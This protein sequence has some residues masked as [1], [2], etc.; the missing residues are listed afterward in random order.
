MSHDRTDR[1]RL[2]RS[3]GQLGDFA[4]VSPFLRTFYGLVLDWV[5]QIDEHPSEIETAFA[6]MLRIEVRHHEAIGQIADAEPPDLAAL[7]ETSQRTREMLGRL[8]HA[9]RHIPRSDEHQ[10]TIRHLLLAECYYHLGQPGHVAQSLRRAIA[11]GC[12]HPLV[13]FALGYNLY[14]RAIRDCVR[15]SD[16]QA[17]FIVADARRFRAIVRQA[18]RAF[19]AGLSADPFDAQLH[20]WVGQLSEVIWERADAASAYARA[21]RLD[22]DTFAE[23]VQGKLR[24]LS[25]AALDATGPAEGERLA[26]LPPIADEDLAELRRG[27]DR[28]DPFPDACA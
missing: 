7:V 3:L 24:K 10:E 19:R 6:L 4:T 23:V 25:T 21:A 14:S 12:R 17:G 8:L 20:W 9:I 27:L 13:Q 11:L 1:Q 15:V 18:V 28:Q 26:G 5:E 2:R 22:P 16:G